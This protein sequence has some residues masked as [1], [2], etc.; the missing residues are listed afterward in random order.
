MY[1]P[2]KRLELQKYLHGN[3][4]TQKTFFYKTKEVSCKKSSLEKAG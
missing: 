4:K 1:F 2:C 3:L